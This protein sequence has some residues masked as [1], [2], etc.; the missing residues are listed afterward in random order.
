MEMEGNP[1]LLGSIFHNLAEN[2]S[3]YSGGTDIFISLAENTPECYTIV[4][5]DNGTGVGEEHLPHL[6]E[7]FYRIDK[8]RS[9]K[10]GG[11]GL[12]LSIVKHAVMAH[13]GS[14]SV[15]NRA[16]GGL[17]FRFSLDRRGGL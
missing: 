5:A 8:G 4:F 6:F 3:A 13:G 1:A 14:V 2:A 15:R 11:T 7:R 10:M 9:R 17:E 16:E 12:G